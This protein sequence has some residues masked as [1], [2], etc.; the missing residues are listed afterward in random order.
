MLQKINDI[1]EYDVKYE[2]WK[3]YQIMYRNNLIKGGKLF[4]DNDIIK[5]DGRPYIKCQFIHN[6]KSTKEMKFSGE[7]D[8]NFSKQKKSELC[9]SRYENYKKF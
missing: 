2:A 1:G 4:T 3:I 9:R 5:D 6:G 7:T 8:F